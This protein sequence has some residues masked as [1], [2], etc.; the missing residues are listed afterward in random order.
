[1]TVENRQFSRVKFAARTLLCCGPEKIE[2]VLVDISM[3][4]ALVQVAPPIPSLHFDSRCE[5]SV[6]LDSSDIVMHFEV[7]LVHARE[8][9]IG[10]KFVGVDID[11]MIHLRSLL[12]FNT[13]DPDQVRNELAIFLG[14]R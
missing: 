7:E 8:N 12:E 1:M 4:G 11:T 14:T 6:S 3:K 2:A 5:L 13:A 9:L 10:M